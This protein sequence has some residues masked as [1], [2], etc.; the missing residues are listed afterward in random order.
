LTILTLAGGIVV[1]LAVHP[2][3]AP[4]CMRGQRPLNADG[5]LLQE[6]VF[7]NVAPVDTHPA[8]HKLMDRPSWKLQYWWQLPKRRRPRNVHDEVYESKA[9]AES[10]RDSLTHFLNDHVERGEAAGH[11]RQCCSCVRT[12]TTGE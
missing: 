8:A 11:P 9:T 2:N 5:M 6:P 4:T 12:S 10:W 7:Y 1:L 3:H